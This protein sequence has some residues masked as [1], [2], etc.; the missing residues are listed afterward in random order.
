MNKFPQSLQSIFW[1]ADL[2]KLDLKKHKKYII[3]QILQY[4]DIKDYLWLK[5]QYLL[6]DIKDIFIKQPESIY[7]YKSFNFTKKYLL[8]LENV[9]NM[10]PLLYKIRQFENWE[11]L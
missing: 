11:Y 9:Q 3:H 4:G 7:T 8:G 2:Q 5:K 10:T 1:S 6:K